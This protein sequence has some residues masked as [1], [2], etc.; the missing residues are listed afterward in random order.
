MY[1]LMIEYKRNVGTTKFK[2]APKM[3]GKHTKLG[4]KCMQNRKNK[5]TEKKKNNKFKNELFKSFNKLII[6][7]KRIIN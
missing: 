1:Y 4:R 7:V 5:G 3:I 2:C 6:E